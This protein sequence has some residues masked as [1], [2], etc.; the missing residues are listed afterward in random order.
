MEDTLAALS[1]LMRATESWRDVTDKEN[2]SKANFEEKQNQFR[3]GLHSVVACCSFEPK[4][5]DCNGVAKLGKS[6]RLLLIAVFLRRFNYNLKIEAIVWEWENGRRSSG[7]KQFEESVLHSDLIE[8]RLCARTKCVALFSR[9]I[10]LWPWWPAKTCFASFFCSTICGK[11]TQQIHHVCSS[12]NF[13]FTLAARL[14]HFP[15]RTQHRY[16]LHLYCLQ[17]LPLINGSFQFVF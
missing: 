10:L 3:G 15:T 16:P 14:V 17:S 4:P 12:D 2:R 8:V 13:Y 9:T 1:Q 11:N 6:I 5:H 7:H